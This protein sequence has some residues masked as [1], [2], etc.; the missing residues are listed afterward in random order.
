MRDQIEFLKRA[1]N[2][3]PSAGPFGCYHV[4]NGRAY[5]QNEQMQASV[6][7]DIADEFSAP[8]VD[9]ETA[10]SRMKNDLSVEL[11]SGILTL[12]SGR[13]RATVPCV[14]IEPPPLYDHSQIEWAPLPSAFLPAIET[15]CPFLIGVQQGWSSAIR[16][17]DGRLTSINNRCGIDIAIPGL[18][19]LPSLLTKECAEFLLSQAAPAQYAYKEN[20]FLFQWDDGHIIQFQLID[21]K[22]PEKIDQIFASAGQLAP[23]EITADWRA[24][25]EDAAAITESVI[26]LR[27]D[28]IRVG[29][30][31][32]KV[33]V[34]LGTP[35]PDGHVSFWETKI[36]TPM[37]TAATHWNPAAYPEKALFKG[38]GLYGIVLGIKQ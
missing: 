6:A 31:S 21:Q 12:R 2:R 29:R 19:C 11:D 16:L 22:M 7:I 1:L 38:P 34:E 23:T 5:A 18:V 33:I 24:A 27:P 26:E 4:Y 28:S 8:G 30:G 35:L 25:Y 36:L 32:S 20:A 3:A 37:L 9:L 10:L 14:V 15:A 13:L 17:M